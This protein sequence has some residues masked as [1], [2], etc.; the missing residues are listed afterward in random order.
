MTKMPSQV[1]SFAGEANTAPYQMFADYFNHYRSLN[2][3][4]NIEFQ[5]SVTTPE[6]VVA[7]LSFSEK[8]DKMNAAL[9][10]EIMRVAGITNFSDFPLESWANHPTLKWATFAVVS[11]MVDMVLPETIIESI[12]IYSD[13]RTIGW[14][15][16]AAFDISPRD[17]FAVSKAGRGKRTTELHKQFK[18]QVTIIP[19][20][21]EMTVFVSLMKVLAGKESLADMV[22]KMARSFETALS[23]DVYNTF[24]TAMDA[25]DATADGLRVAGYSQ[26]E[27]VRLSQTVA[28]WNGGAKPICIG[29]QLAL[30]HILP[31]NANYRYEIDS[32]FV[33][34]GY[35]RNFQGTDI[36]VLP[37]VADY[38][39][40]FG[41]L[42]S[43]AKIWFVSPSSQKIVKVVL[44]GSV[45]SY[46]S[47]VY[48]NANL[49]Q[50]STL[51]KS[52]GTGIAT[53]AVAGIMSV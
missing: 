5:S 18:G 22:M 44:E 33:K 46:T 26:A 31:A 28:A 38:S 19:E 14:G 35:L 41:L 48:A 11:A 42:L 29:T 16:S 34:V 15:D 17:L 47:D 49:L 9:K 3:A 50:T 23:L 43:D 21:R 40:P 2:G 51:I 30:A 52:W 24:V 6:G 4:K 37:Q 27:F 32:E 25:V 39:T 7:P 13:V 45:M 1:L 53:N 36:M 10:R 20:P 12:G 8:E